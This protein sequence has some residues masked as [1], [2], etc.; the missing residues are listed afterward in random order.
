MGTLNFDSSAH[1][2]GLPHGSLHKSE[3]GPPI[4][5]QRG[6]EDDAPCLSK[7]ENPLYVRHRQEARV[8]QCLT[9]VGRSRP[10]GGGCP[11]SLGGRLC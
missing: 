1:C 4:S 2:P 9:G 6:L 10:V 7:V 8:V 5:V 3:I 11:P